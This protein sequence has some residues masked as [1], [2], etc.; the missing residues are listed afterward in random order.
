MTAGKQAR[1]LQTHFRN[2]V[3]LVWVSLRLAPINRFLSFLCLQV[4]S[5]IFHIQ[6]HM[7]YYSAYYKIRNMFRD[8]EHHCTGLVYNETVKLSPS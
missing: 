1:T 8:R 6:V 3:L 5:V 7:V 2:A 4:A